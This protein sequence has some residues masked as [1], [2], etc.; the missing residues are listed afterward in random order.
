MTTTLTPENNEI[1]AEKVILEQTL[2]YVRMSMMTNLS[3]R[4][5]NM[6][7]LVEGLIHSRI[8]ELWLECAPIRSETFRDWL[9]R[10]LEARDAE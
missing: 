2:R 7:I 8:R 9:N 6:L 1:E 10:L 3:Q 4:S 5:G